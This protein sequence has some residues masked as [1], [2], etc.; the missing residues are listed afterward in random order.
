MNVR[1]IGALA[2]EPGLYYHSPVGLVLLREISL[3]PKLAVVRKSLFRTEGFKQITTELMPRLF[4]YPWHYDQALWFQG[5]T[6][7]HN[8]FM[9]QFSVDPNTGW[10]LHPI[11]SSFMQRPPTPLVSRT[12]V[13]RK[14]KR[15]RSE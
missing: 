5:L 7:T 2:I 12:P 13:P 3:Y 6:R 10:R 1:L 15:K 8:K 11:Q 4:L 14:A 9:K